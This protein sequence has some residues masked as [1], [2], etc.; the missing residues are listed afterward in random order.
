ETLIA[1]RPRSP[2]PAS[3][4]GGHFVAQLVGPIRE[5]TLL[6]WVCALTLTL[7]MLSVPSADQHTTTHLYLPPG[8]MINHREHPAVASA[9]SMPPAWNWESDVISIMAETSS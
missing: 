1:Q 4:A 8:F 5:R 9:A 3:G 6:H 2:S 7:P